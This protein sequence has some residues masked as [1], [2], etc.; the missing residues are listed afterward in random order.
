MKTGGW[1]AHHLEITCGVQSTSA[2]SLEHSASRT[3][4][5][6]RARVKVAPAISLHLPLESC[7][8]ES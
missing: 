5:A 1:G 4:E 2:E 8:F 6:G 3:R 7:C